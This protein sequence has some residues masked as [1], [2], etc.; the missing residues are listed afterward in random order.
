[1]LDFDAIDDSLIIGSAF[2]AED[3][4]LLRE[5]RVGA[6][7]NLQ[8]EAADPEDA[9]AEHG[10]VH[11]RVACDD[12]RAPPLGRLEEAVSRIGAFHDEGHRVYL[13][14]FAGLQRAVTV[15]ACYLVASDPD[16]WNARSALDEVIAK[17]R[18]ACPL[19]EQ[20]DAILDFDRYVRVN[21]AR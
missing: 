13:H 5:L 6:V 10:I 3:V 20:I 7:V 11:A 1:M 17:R 8:S 19:R 16:R 2:R 18:N 21:R 15:G 14:C 4:P 9:L 12:F